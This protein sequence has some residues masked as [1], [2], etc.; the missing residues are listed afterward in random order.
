MAAKP[1]S[2][3]Q[4]QKLNV[5][6]Q[7]AVA[8]HQSGDLAQA[9]RG[10]QKALQ[11]APGFPEALHLL[12]LVRYQSGEHA[13]AVEL[14]REA[15]RAG[16]NALFYFN[17]GKVEKDRGRLAEAVQAFTQALRL[18]PNYYQAAVNLGG[19]Y[20]AM[21]LLDEAIAQFELALSI[22]PND[23]LAINNL[24]TALRARGQHSRA[25]ECYRRAIELQP[26]YA[27]AHANLSTLLRERGL[28]DESEDLC[29]QAVNL[30]PN[31]PEL[32]THLGNTLHKRGRYDDA[33]GSYRQALA[34]DASCTTAL[35]GIGNTLREQG[36]LDEAIKWL[37]KGLEQGA[38]ARFDN[39]YWACLLFTLNYNPRVSCAESFAY[40]QRFGAAVA[41]RNA[42]LDW[43]APA[44]TNTRE[45]GR[46]LRI[47]FVSPD[48]RVH[49]C[50]YFLL[51]L[52]S[53]LDRVA[54]EIVCYA[55][56]V[57]P[58][59]VTERFR[60][61]AD[62]WCDTVGMSDRE[63]AMQI[64]AD[65]IDILLDIAGHT[66]NNRL[67]VFG[68]RPA[69][70]QMSWLGYP[71]TT[72]LRTMDY[73]LTDAIADPDGD[74]SNNKCYSEQLLRLPQS[75]LCFR[76]L[77]PMPE[78]SPLPAARTG[79]VTF[80]SLNNFSKVTPEVLDLWA[81]LLNAV[82]GSR[83]LLKAKQ[84]EDAGVRRHVTEYFIEQGIGEERLSLM[85]ALP[86]REDHFAQYHAIDIGLDPFPY[87]GTTTTCEALWM[88]VPVI[89]V[90]GDRHA[91]RVGASLLTHAGLSELVADDAAEFLRIAG[92]LAHNHEKLVELRAELRARLQGSVL[93]DEVGFTR[94]MEEALRSAWQSWGASGIA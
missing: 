23:A 35:A 83:I 81:Q 52:L 30:N 79:H 70:V 69:P 86:A 68:L 11:E 17:L 54:F 15:L 2:P 47:G 90:R 12:G 61:L 50:A 85:A 93:C 58:D 22:Q 31:E 71:N 91:A 63:L 13:A 1:L 65:G 3:K 20:Q 41:R 7:A 37:L 36:A 27:E 18:Q 78:V 89:T 14:I 33:C 24:G 34:L 84:L 53:N 32:W 67:P 10:Y 5:L 28:L 87:N 49:S 62:Q 88:G 66:E 29:R 6:M 26:R 92:A 64:T 77:T 80:G 39:T 72:G 38:A 21:G 75:F 9:A 40:H 4:L 60:K 42:A 43:R 57:R 8:A 94:A 46:R 56:V 55:E 25:E 19:T 76:P 74:V 44:F 48:F 45:P 82:P 51:P 16:G 59:E 73:R